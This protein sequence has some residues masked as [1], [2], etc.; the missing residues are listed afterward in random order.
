MTLMDVDICYSS[1]FLQY[2]VSL[3]CQ[4]VVTYCFALLLVTSVPRNHYDKVGSYFLCIERVKLR[5]KGF[6][7]TTDLAL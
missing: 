1:T 3:H 4:V 2:N 5:W 6:L 7:K